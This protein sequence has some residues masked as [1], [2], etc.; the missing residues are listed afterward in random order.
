MSS[1]NQGSQKNR[2]VVRILNRFVT[3]A[4]F[5]TLGIFIIYMILNAFAIDFTTGMR[6]LLAGLLPPL[7]ITYISYFT[8][9]FKG[10]YRSDIPRINLYVISTLWLIIILL[11]FNVLYDPENLLPIPIVQLLFSSTL[12]ILITLYKA[13]DYA[14]ALAA[15]YGIISGLLIFVVFIDR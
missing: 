15:S 6:S 13:K 8:K 3:V 14:T 4:S 1:S 7:A 9:V 10:P 5:V 2:P 12:V 11:I